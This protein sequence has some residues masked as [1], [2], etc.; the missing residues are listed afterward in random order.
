MSD[1][2]YQL[3]PDANRWKIA[4]RAFF[5]QTQGLILAITA[6]ERDPTESRL[7]DIVELLLGSPVMMMFAAD[8]LEEDYK[9]VRNDMTRVD[10]KFSGQYSA[11]HAEFL[12][13]S[14]GLRAAQVRFPEAHD[15]Y[16]AALEAVFETHAL[17]CKSFVGSEGSLAN[18]DADGPELLRT[19]FLRK[20]LIIAGAV[21]RARATDRRGRNDA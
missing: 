21:D 10:E 12:N 11:D 5:T 2:T 19:K 16:A 14:R 15:R 20:A 17:V 9:W 8:F 7:E 3:S 1:P 18:P 13:R 6:Y 4:H